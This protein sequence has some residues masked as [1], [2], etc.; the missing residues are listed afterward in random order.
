MAICPPLIPTDKPATQS[1]TL[2]QLPLLTSYFVSYCLIHQRGGGAGRVTGL[3]VQLSI[4]LCVCV[5][6]GMKQAMEQM[7]MTGNLN[8]FMLFQYESIFY[9]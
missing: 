5:Y 9:L 7:E 3:G 8:G 1:N 4:C 2:G 6:R